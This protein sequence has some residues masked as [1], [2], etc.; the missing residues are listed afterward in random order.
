MSNTRPIKRDL[1]P[2]QKA[3]LRE[4]AKKLGWPVS[5]LIAVMEE[6]LHDQLNSNYWSLLVPAIDHYEARPSPLHGVGVFASVR[7]RQGQAVRPGVIGLGL[8]HSNQPNTRRIGT[9]VLG[10]RAIRDIEIG[11]EITVAEPSLPEVG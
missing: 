6:L 3:W 7:I 11:E 9:G 2:K 5:R 10:L 4:R 1:T 8:N